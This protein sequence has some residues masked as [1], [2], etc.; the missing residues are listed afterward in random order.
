MNIMIDDIDSYLGKTVLANITVYDSRSSAMEDI[1]IHG[2]M[3]AFEEPGIVVI[4]QADGTGH[5]RA[6]FSKNAMHPAEPGEYRLWHK[7]YIANN[8][9]FLLS[10]V[11][12]LSEDQTIEAMRS[13]GLTAG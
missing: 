8:P 5:F 13:T 9:D 10:M 2:T 4:E 6:P 11:H 7:G 12:N 1:Q 3:I